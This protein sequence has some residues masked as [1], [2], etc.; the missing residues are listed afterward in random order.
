MVNGVRC[1]LSEQGLG[2]TLAALGG[3]QYK[4]GH[5]CAHFKMIYSAHVGRL[6]M[7]AAQN[8]PVGGNQSKSCTHNYTHRMMKV[9]EL[10]LALKL[11]V[12]RV[13]G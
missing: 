10:V 7:W 3:S 4:W 12:L 13:L 6:W 1:L 5:T 11:G 2:C 9:S 8:N